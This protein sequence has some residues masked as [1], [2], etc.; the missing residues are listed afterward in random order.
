MP[1]YRADGLARLL[2]QS[3]GD[4][5][6]GHILNLFPWL[7]GPGGSYGEN[8]SQVLLF[9]FAPLDRYPV[10][11]THRM[12]VFAGDFAHVVEIRKER[13]T[14]GHIPVDQDVDLLVIRP[15]SLNQVPTVHEAYVQDVIE[16]Q[17]EK[18]VE[19]AADFHNLAQDLSASI[20]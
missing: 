13:Q 2:T 15:G 11:L 7:R 9:V 16:M 4:K 10:A 19:V 8:I 6:N 12:I 3:V 14:M 17:H 18:S 5:D 20:Q 1:P